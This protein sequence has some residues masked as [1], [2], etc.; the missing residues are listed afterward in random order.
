MSGVIRLSPWH[1]WLTSGYVYATVLERAIELAVEQDESKVAH[2]LNS[3]L[4]MRVLLATDENALEFHR[5]VHFTS[6]AARQLAEESDISRFADL[7][8]M[9]THRM[10]LDSL[11]DHDPDLD[12]HPDGQW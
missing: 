6:E 10:N 12:A 11:A 8:R 4:D 7:L 3:S 5:M 1:R 2:E 9:L